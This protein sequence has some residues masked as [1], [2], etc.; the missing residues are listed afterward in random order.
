MGELCNRNMEAE[1]LI[2]NFSGRYE[3]YICNMR[4]LRVDSSVIFKCVMVLDMKL[5]E[6]GYVLWRA[7]VSFTKGH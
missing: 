5:S 3:W 2:N 4:G 7:F 1:K 6:L